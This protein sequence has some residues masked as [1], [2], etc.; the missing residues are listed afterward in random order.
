MS[1]C[2]VVTRGYLGDPWNTRRIV[3][4]CNSHGAAMAAFRLLDADYWW[5]TFW[6]EGSDQ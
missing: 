3:A 5:E 2:Y 1:G 6:G 4:V